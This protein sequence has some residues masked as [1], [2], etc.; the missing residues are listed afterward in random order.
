MVTVL[1]RE[2]SIG[3]RFGAGLGAGLQQLLQNKIAQRQ[4]REQGSALESLGLPSALASLPPQLQSAAMQSLGGS[5]GGTNEDVEYLVEN[6]G[7]PE[8]EARLY[9]SLTPG[10]QTEYAKRYL[11]RRERGGSQPYSP[12]ERRVPSPARA[13][14]IEE[15]AA[16]EK[17][18]PEGEVVQEEEFFTDPFEGLTA[19]EKISKESELRK[20]NYPIYEE[21]LKT[22]RAL[23]K[24]GNNLKTL[25]TLNDNNRLPKGLQRLNINWKSGSLIFPAA[26]NEDTQLFVKTVNDFTTLAKDSFGARVTNFELDRFMQRLPSLLNSEKGRGA[27]L[28]QMDLISQM[29]QIYEEELRQ[30]Y[31]ERGGIHRLEPFEAQEAAYSR[32][33]K[34]TKPL[35]EKYHQ[36]L[37]RNPSESA[38]QV[39]VRLPDGRTATISQAEWDQIGEEKKAALEVL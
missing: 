5:G 35:V 8:E 39:R 34:K 16:S 18:S 25:Q 17:P 3:E 38:R 29:D 15:I 10:G 2:E 12:K 6:L 20:V 26:A 11:E 32:A 33:V 37:K 36:S 24:V 23:E 4:T 28:K 31:K 9:L 7:W 30:V 27:I 14:A 1:P 13:P 21:S 22:R 19:K